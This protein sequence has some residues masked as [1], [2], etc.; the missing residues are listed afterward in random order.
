MPAV[1]KPSDEKRILFG[2]PSNNVQAGIVGMPNVG[3]STT[4]N[5]M[6]NMTVAAE[7]FPFCTIDPSEARVEVPDPNFRHLCDQFKPKSEVPAYLK[8][9][10]IAG[11]VKGA[12]EGEGLGNAFLSHISACDAIY[13]VCRTFEDTIDGD[14]AAHVEG[15]VDPVR[16]L[17]IIADELRK[18]DI[19]T[20]TKV[21][22]PLKKEVARDGKNKAAK[23][24]LESTQKVYEWLTQTGKDVR[25]GEWTNKDIDVLNDYNLLTAKPAIYLV[26]MSEKDLI[27]KKNKYLPKLHAWLSEHR[28]GEKM[29]PYSA[30]IEAKWVEF[31]QEEKVAFEAEHKVGS[32]MPRIVTAGYHGLGLIHFY[33]AGTD[34]VKCWT[35]RDGWTAPK[36]AGTIHTDF[37]R[38][39]IKAEVYAFEDYKALGSEA[40]VKEAG[41]YRT[42]GKNYEVKDG[43]VIFFKFNVTADAKKK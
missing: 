19:S 35:V 25:F 9:F 32:Q 30:A 21:L 14:T 37:E 39:F 33:T 11:L 29:Y 23:D 7:N 22:E 6:C 16:D 34:E 10:D 31:T 38:G 8:V 40:A 5:V 3:K 13:H 2:R 36:A 4:F 18:K 43:D 26:N 41:K 42:E 28:P 1:R 15:D 17:E 24:K 12:S 27:R 20:V